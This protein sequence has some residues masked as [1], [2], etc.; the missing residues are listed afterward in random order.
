MI[1]K[2]FFSIRA[3]WYI[4]DFSE[5]IWEGFSKAISRLVNMTRL[6]ER[7]PFFQSE[8]TNIS[9]P[10]QPIKLSAA[11]TKRSFLLC[12]R[13]SLKILFSLR[14]FF[15]LFSVSFLYLVNFFVSSRDKQVEKE[16]QVRCPK[17]NVPPISMEFLLGIFPSF[18]DHSSDR[19]SRRHLFKARRCKRITWRTIINITHLDS[20][21]WLSSA[22]NKNVTNRSS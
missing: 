5:W 8:E 15:S 14:P 10:S 13:F 7:F 9:L 2:I 17:T 16:A 6:V 19:G 20:R 4:E 18:L 1:S 11:T 21:F 12:L 22:A 3:I